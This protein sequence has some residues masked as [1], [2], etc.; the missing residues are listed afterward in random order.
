MLLHTLSYVNDRDA[1]TS[2]EGRDDSMEDRGL[3]TISKKH[4]GEDRRRTGANASQPAQPK[5]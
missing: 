4:E 3:K 5:K 2:T 1:S